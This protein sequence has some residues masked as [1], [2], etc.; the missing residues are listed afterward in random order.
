MNRH[1][2][3]GISSSSLR[4]MSAGLAAWPWRRLFARFRIALAEELDAR[5]LAS[6]AD[7]TG[8]HPCRRVDGV[9]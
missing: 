6:F 7:D 1:V 5:E 8:A 9:Q 2:F 3:D 4:A